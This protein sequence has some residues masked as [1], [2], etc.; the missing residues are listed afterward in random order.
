MGQMDN[1]EE[2]KT[3]NVVNVRM[4]PKVQQAWQAL[5]KASNLRASDL[6]A[7]LIERYKTDEAITGKPENTSKVAEVRK[8]TDAL[9]AMFIGVM[10]SADATLLA[11]N[12]AHNKALSSKDHII[13]DLQA[14]LEAANTATKNV[15]IFQKRAEK[16]EADVARLREELQSIRPVLHRLKH[17]EEDYAKIP[18]LKEELTIA[19]AQLEVYKQLLPNSSQD[20]AVTP[21][22]FSEYRS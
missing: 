7:T 20:N 21:P 18:Q 4:E 17:L 22:A 11:T 6:M 10:E 1:P 2:N 12:E 5:Q 15:M 9:I 8:L 3:T 14:K 19:K 16:A 13:Q